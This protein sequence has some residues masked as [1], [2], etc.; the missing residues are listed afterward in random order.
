MVIFY[1][2]EATTRTGRTSASLFFPPLFRNKFLNIWPLFKRFLID[3][4]S[5]S[6]HEQ[7]TANESWGS[8][9]TSH[10]SSYDYQDCVSPPHAPAKCWQ[11]LFFR[12]T[13][14]VIMIFIFSGYLDY[15][16]EIIIVTGS[17][18]VVRMDSVQDVR[19]FLENFPE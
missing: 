16:V 17:Q 11:S 10:C 14:T 8:L 15:T 13:T 1:T 2:M 9:Q 12:S 4:M 5:S 7:C 6:A 19:F 3:L 18:H